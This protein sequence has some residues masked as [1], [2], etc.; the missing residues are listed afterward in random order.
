MKKTVIEVQGYDQPGRMRPQPHISKEVQTDKSMT[1]I[2]RRTEITNLGTR[3]AASD[4]LIAAPMEVS[5]GG[6][7]SE[8]DRGRH[9]FEARDSQ[10]HIS[11]FEEILKD[12]DDAIH[13]DPMFPNSK[14]VDYEIL[15][16]QIVISCN[17][18]DIAVMEDDCV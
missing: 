16:N 14:A 5:G 6:G 17:L 15:A 13:N 2:P 9:E 12:I 8:G 1:K 7:E 3:K 18:V 4:S 10:K 11:D